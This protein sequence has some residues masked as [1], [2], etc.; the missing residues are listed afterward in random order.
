LVR[1][2]ELGLDNF[3]EEWLSMHPEKDPKRRFQRWQSYKKYAENFQMRMR[4]AYEKESSIIQRLTDSE[5]LVKKS[6][7]KP[8]L[9]NLL[10]RLK[11][12]TKETGKMSALANFLDVPLASVSRWL[13]GNREPGGEVTLKLL[14]WVEQQERQK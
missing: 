11:A 10:A 9:P 12:A 3:V 8:Q 5:S 4:E 13:S 7:V 2:F 6:H 14:R 1:D